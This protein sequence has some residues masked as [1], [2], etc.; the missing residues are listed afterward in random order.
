MAPFGTRGSDACQKVCTVYIVHASRSG[1]GV[2]CTEQ[3]TLPRYYLH[4]Y[5]SC[6]AGREAALGRD[7]TDRQTASLGK[8]ACARVRG[9]LSL[10]TP[11]STSGAKLCGSWSPTTDYLG[12]NLSVGPRHGALH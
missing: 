8:V 2:V 12:I 4:M 1:L 10:Q 6:P 9:R 11:A 7:K 3:H 5:L